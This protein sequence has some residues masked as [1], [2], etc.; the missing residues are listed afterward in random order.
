MKNKAD[1]PLVYI[2]ILHFNDP[3]H[4]LLA[5]ESAQKQSYPN[6]QIVVIDNHSEH[7]PKRILDKFSDI[8][9]LY[10]EKNLGYAAA[11]NFGMDYAF[12][13][14]ADFA[15][16]QNADVELEN[17]CLSEMINLWQKE[18]GQ[19]G[20]VQPKILLQ[21][22]RNIINTDGNAIHI[23]GFGYCKNYKMKDQKV[24]KNH[25]ILSASGACLLV[26]QQYYHSVG[27]FDENFFLYNE[28]QAYS[29]RGLLLAYHHFLCSSAIAYH[30]YSFSKNTGKMLFSE[31]NRL[32]SL[33]MFYSLKSLLLLFPIFFVTE[34][35][36]ILTSILEGWFFT[37]MKSYWRFFTQL[38]LT[39]EKR[40]QIQ[41]SRKVPDS[42]LMRTF[43]TK[44]NFA[45]FS[46]KHIGL[47]NFVFEK[48][49]KLFL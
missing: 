34:I 31:S 5:I 10:L 48:Y 43:D 36:I 38:S 14:Q 29:W 46:G 20:L 32:S 19:I 12:H 49:I 47:F 42:Q 41:K 24:E 45:E 27:K 44:L 9:T 21:K 15:L 39:L 2:L 25:E 18:K 3:E 40:N 17:S 30:D 28:D 22:K 1:F 11:N 6:K 16:L 7:S 13:R 35:G 26:S 8:K 37:K 23:L 33:I 4:L